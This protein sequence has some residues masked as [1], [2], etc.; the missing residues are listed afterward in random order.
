MKFL[1]NLWNNFAQAVD[2]FIAGIIGE[3]AVD[4]LESTPQE[5][6]AMVETD[7]FESW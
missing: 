4:Q 1:S 3:D 2:E 6:A 7:S 5:I